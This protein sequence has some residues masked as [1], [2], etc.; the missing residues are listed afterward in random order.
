VNNCENCRNM[1]DNRLKFHNFFFFSQNFRSMSVVIKTPFYINIRF[2]KN[3]QRRANWARKCHL[4]LSDIKP[5]A[6]VC[7]AH[8]SPTCFKKMEGRYRILR[9]D[10]VPT[11]FN[12]SG[13]FGMSLNIVAEADER[14]TNNIELHFGDEGTNVKG[15]TARSSSP[16]SQT[17][18]GHLFFFD[19]ETDLCLFISS[20]QF[21]F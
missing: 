7:S 6:I 15:E 8:F 9:S 21:V 19:G 18:S 10:A 2:P 3:L 1:Y 12:R 17:V 4:S 11:N 5:K 16:T 14:P 20:P 13:V